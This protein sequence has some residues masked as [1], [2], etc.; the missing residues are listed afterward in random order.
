MTFTC[1]HK[2]F[3]AAANHPS[4][5]YLGR[6]NVYSDVQTSTYIRPLSQTECSGMSFIPGRLRDFDLATFQKRIPT[7]VLDEVRIYTRTKQAILY[8]FF[9]FRGRAKIV[10]GWLLTSNE[11]E[12][13]MQHVTGPTWRSRD[14]MDACRIYLGITSPTARAA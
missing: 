8:Q 14:V 6:G 3:T 12:L 11:H 5:G 7:P 1:A 9:H 4:A 10:H 2:G 13:I